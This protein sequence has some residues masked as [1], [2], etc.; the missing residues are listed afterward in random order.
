MKRNAVWSLGALMLL[1]ILVT[2]SS[3]QPLQ[4]IKERKADKIAIADGMQAVADDRQ[5]LNRLS[6]LVIRWD[7]LRKSGADPAELKVVENQIAVELRR[8]L[9]ETKM[10]AK[11]A[12]MEVKQS[13]AEVKRSKRELRHEKMDGDRDKAAKRD[14]RRDL[15]DDR[16]DQVNDLKDAQQAEEILTKKREIVR[17]LIAV[18]HKLDAAGAAGDRILREK[19]VKLLEDYLVVSR[20]ELKMDLR[21]VKED[22]KELRE[23]R[24]EKR[25]DRRK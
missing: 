14:D 24:R 19:Q 15:R 9:K 7:D 2:Q 5:D 10:D 6:K 13:T 18:Q 20:Q 4:G 8:D 12:Q 23:D 11:Q 21:E 17:E 3:A 16:R 22:Q 1:V 25:E